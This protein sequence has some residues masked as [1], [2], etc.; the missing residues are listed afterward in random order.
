[1]K[2]SEQGEALFRTIPAGRYAVSVTRRVGHV[3]AHIVISPK[4]RGARSSRIIFGI[5]RRIEVR[6][7][8]YVLNGITVLESEASPVIRISHLS[9]FPTVGEISHTI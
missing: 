8:G 1:M 9:P 6:G 2:V 4:A 5:Y 7:D 3:Q